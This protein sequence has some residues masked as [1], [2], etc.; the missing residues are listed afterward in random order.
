[1]SD[2]TQAYPDTL[3]DFIRHGEPVGG[4]RYRGNG[5]DDPLSEHGWSQ[6][7]GALGDPVP[8][9]G[10]VASPLQRC[11]AFAEALA[12]RH[13]L[14]LR[15]EPGF[16][17]VGFGCWEGRSPGE[18][19]ARDPEAYEAFY[20][21]PVTNRPM[22]AEPLGD[23]LARI[24]GAYEGLVASQPGKHILVVCHAGVIRAV[25][26]HILRAEPGRWYRIRIDNAGVTRI[27]RSRHGD[28]LEFHNGSLAH[29]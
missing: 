16:R 29:S 15:V 6:M 1:M 8:W 14:P 13:G 9:D 21:D 27:F 19:M 7:W 5:I 23:F 2:E 26:G 24:G 11:R 18:V 10:I 12:E 22:G 25:I 4:R 28:R 3:V 17:E 20:R